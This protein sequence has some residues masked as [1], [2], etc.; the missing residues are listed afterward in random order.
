MSKVVTGRG[1][2]EGVTGEDMGEGKG[3]GKTSVDTSTGISSETTFFEA[4]KGFLV[5]GV[6]G[7]TSEVSP[8]AAGFFLLDTFARGSFPEDTVLKLTLWGI[9]HDPEAC[10][11]A[12]SVTTKEKDK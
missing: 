1:I 12:R 10:F 6:E 7:G 2:V 11:W 9:I 8:E 5:T 3:R 4:F